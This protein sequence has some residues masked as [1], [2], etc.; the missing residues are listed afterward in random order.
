VGSGT[1]MIGERAVDYRYGL[2]WRS[3]EEVVLD[4]EIVKRHLRNDDWYDLHASY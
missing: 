2:N 1:G 3:A 4:E